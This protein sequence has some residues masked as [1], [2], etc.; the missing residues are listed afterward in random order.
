MT[1]Y[2][3]VETLQLITHNSTPVITTELLANLYG[4]EAA[5]VRKNHHRNAERFSVGK[6]FYKV[7]GSELDTLRV[8]LRH[9]QISPKTRSLILWTE[10]GAAR[11]AKML[12]T[13]QAWEVFEKLEDYYFNAKAELEQQ[14]AKT[15]Q[16]SATQ[17]I[18]LRQTAERLIATGIGNIYPDIWKLVH[19]RFDIEH[20]HQL[21]PHQVGEAIEYLNA[22]E[23]EFLGKQDKQVSLPISYPMEYFDQFKWIIGSVNL[24]A[25]WRYPAGMLVPNGDY[26]NPCG[27]LLGDLKNAGYE[28]DAALFQLLS[29]QHHLEMLRGKVNAIDRAINGK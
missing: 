19:S 11:H 10:R 23:G 21:Q 20:I 24:S 16:S 1:N 25:P 12:E 5:R 29:L 22:I 14:R 2:P 6:H 3:S 13:D 4:T 18:P 28:V 8:S 27:R 26:P 9:L 17:L 15:R 7:T